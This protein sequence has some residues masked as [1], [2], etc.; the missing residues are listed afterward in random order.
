MK[1]T[2]Y[3]NVVA[4]TNDKMKDTMVKVSMVM[5]SRMGEHLNPMRVLHQD[6]TSTLLN[7]D[8]SPNLEYLL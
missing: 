2:T 1:V 5:A 6:V 4:K 7:V 8:F 3:N